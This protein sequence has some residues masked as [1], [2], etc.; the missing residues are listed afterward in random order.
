MRLP[1]KLSLPQKRKAKTKNSQRVGLNSNV[2]TRK[3]SCSEDAFFFVMG[4]V[5][6]FKPIFARHILAPM[7]H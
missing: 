5:G 1:K 6:S 3:A 2:Q 4:H 7:V